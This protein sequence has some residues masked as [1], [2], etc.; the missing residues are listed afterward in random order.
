MLHAFRQVL[1]LSPLLRLERRFEKF[2]PFD[3]IETA[4]QRLHLGQ[5]TDVVSVLAVQLKKRKNSNQE[6]TPM[7]EPK[8]RDR[9]TRIR[10][11]LM[12]ELNVFSK[13]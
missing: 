8:T 10:K 1:Q 7:G 9:L 11:Q 4:L 5:Q 6:V 13:F 3:I 2:L 12:Q